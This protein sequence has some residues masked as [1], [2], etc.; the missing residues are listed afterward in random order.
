M[1]EATVVFLESVE[2]TRGQGPEDRV[3]IGSEAG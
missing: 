3:A 1:H 2:H